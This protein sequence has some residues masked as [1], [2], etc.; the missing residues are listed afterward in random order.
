MIIHFCLIACVPSKV[1]PRTSVRH[2]SGNN[3]TR[4]SFPFSLLRVPLAPE[5]HEECL[6]LSEWEHMAWDCCRPVLLLPAPGGLVS[7]LIGHMDVCPCDIGTFCGCHDMKKVGST[8][9]RHPLAL[10][11][12]DRYFPFLFLVLIFFSTKPKRPQRGG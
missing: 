3:Y 8:G 12:Y 9:L 6:P 11:F 10:R 7:T 1:S 4:Q 5:G 2:V